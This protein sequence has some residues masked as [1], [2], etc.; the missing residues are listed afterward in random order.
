MPFKRFFDRLFGVHSFMDHKHTWFNFLA[1]TF[2]VMCFFM[3]IDHMGEDCELKYGSLAFLFL[4]I[5]N[6][7]LFWYSGR[8]QWQEASRFQCI[9]METTHIIFL[10]IIPL[11]SV[12]QYY[13]SDLGCY[14]LGLVLLLPML[15]LIPLLRNKLG[16][17][18]LYVLILK[19][20]IFFNLLVSIRTT[21]FGN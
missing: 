4:C 19:T 11:I 2:V 6:L 15:Y 8:N 7:S 21:F 1:S 13:K 10:L 16:R 5:D 17:C 3:Y 20:S 12:N 9:I 14:Y 18:N